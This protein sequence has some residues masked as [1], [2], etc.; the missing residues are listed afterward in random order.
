MSSPAASLDGGALGKVRWENDMEILM[1][2]LKVFPERLDDFI[3]EMIEDA[4][5]S[6]LNEPG[7][8]RF[9]IIQD[10]EDPTSLALCEVYNDGLAIEDHQTRPHF[11]KWRDTTRDW[12]AEEGAVSRCCPVF[13]VGDANWDSA[14][15]YGRG[16]GFNESFWTGGLHVI[17]APLPVK[18][19]RVDDF[20]EAVRLDALGSVRNEPG[21]LR[22][23]VYQNLDRPSELYLYEVYVN[24][25]AFEYHTKTPHIAKW[26]ETVEE[27][28][29][30]ERTGSRRGRNIWPPDNWG[31]S[32]GV[33]RA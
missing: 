30:G 4:R 15:R 18:P 2:R 16:S 11:T 33:P 23:D 28:Y 22:F 32:S 26:R 6:V 14:P 19:E 29:A 8:R 1:V 5:G 21:C 9:D 3:K 7:C 12:M 24:Q 10:L 17:H 13:P 25:A 27:W 31:W 20:I